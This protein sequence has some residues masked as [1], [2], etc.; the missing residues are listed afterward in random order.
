VS[1]STA[2]RLGAAAASGVLLALAR[3]PFGLGPLSL[4]A[5]VPLLWTWR[6]ASPKRALATGLFGGAVYYAILVN[7]TWYFGAVAIVPLVFALAAYWGLAGALIAWL[8]RRGLRAPWLTASVWVVAEAGVARWPFGG[9][10]WG[11][12][13]YALTGVPAARAVA[14]FGGVAF[15]SF[16]AVATNAFLLDAAIA[17]RDRVRAGGRMRPLLAAVGGLA[18]VALVLP[19]AAD[20]AWMHPRETAR[21]HVALVQGNNLDRDLTDAE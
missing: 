8:A 1:R 19:A 7:W 17:T 6:G 2:A 12:V 21:F 15:V 9:L 11:E 18:A 5:L 16:L 10:S 20:V 13:G 14:S 4:V 3:P